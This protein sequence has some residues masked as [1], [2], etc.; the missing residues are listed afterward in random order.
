MLTI[1]DYRKE[2]LGDDIY[3]PDSLGELLEDG[4]AMALEVDMPLYEPDWEE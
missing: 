4:L 1:S 3:L 2:E